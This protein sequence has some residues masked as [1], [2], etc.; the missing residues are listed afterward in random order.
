MK[1]QGEDGYLELQRSIFGPQTE[2]VDRDILLTISVRVFGYSAADQAWVTAKDYARFL[3]DLQKLQ[4]NQ[5][6]NAVLEGSAPGEFRLEFYAS[7]SPDHMAL[8]G[9]VRWNTPHGH[10]L[11]LQFGFDFEPSR[12]DRILRDLRALS[13]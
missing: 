10:P 7:D 8:R 13:A 4:A 2:P 3:L 12:L 5:K 6:G 11:K 1:I 9:H